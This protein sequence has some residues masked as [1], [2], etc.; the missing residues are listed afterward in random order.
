MSS[1]TA[2]AGSSRRPLPKLHRDDAV[3]K[4]HANHAF[5]GVLLSSNGSKP[6][7][8]T[9]VGRLYLHFGNMG[10]FLCAW[11]VYVSIRSHFYPSRN[12]GLLSWTETV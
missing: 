4:K 7:V 8:M 3:R 6:E 9:G 5:D 12:Q 1:F 2:A 11:L 10:S